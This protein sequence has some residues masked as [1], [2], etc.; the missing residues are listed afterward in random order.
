M[1]LDTI[2]KIRWNIMIVSYGMNFPS[3]INLLMHTTY[4]LK[5]WLSMKHIRRIYLSDTHS[6]VFSFYVMYAW[7]LYKDFSHNVSKKY[8]QLSNILEILYCGE[9]CCEF[10]DFSYLIVLS[11]NFVTYYIYDLWTIATLNLFI[12]YFKMFTEN[13]CSFLMYDWHS[14]SNC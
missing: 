9:R 14:N 5:L 2:G 3:V 6:F 13:N 8:G 7:T 10:L 11:F 4:F 12:I 1:N